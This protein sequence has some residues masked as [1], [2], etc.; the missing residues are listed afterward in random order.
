MILLGVT[1]VI[2]LQFS[3]IYTVVE[4]IWGIV[5]CSARD[6]QYITG[7]IISGHWITTSACCDVLGVNRLCELYSSELAR[8]LFGGRKLYLW[9]AFPWI[10]GAVACFFMHG[11]FFNSYMMAFF[12]NPHD[13]YF[14]E[15]GFVRSGNTR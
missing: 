6:F 3:G 11:M 12:N 5:F 9:M 2:G 7:C 4:T 10:Y 13:P 15:V 14:P 1:Q 8:K